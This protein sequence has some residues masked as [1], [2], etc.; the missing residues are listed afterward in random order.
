M[1]ENN[2]NN[3]DD[4]FENNSLNRE[5]E[6]L[7]EVF[8]NI[9][10][11]EQLDDEKVDESNDNLIITK[12]QRGG[13]KLCYRG[14]F[15]TIDATTTEKI[16]WKCE[17][18][19]TTKKFIKCGGRVHSN[20]RRHPVVE[21]KEHNHLPNPE[22]TECLVVIDEA[23]N[24]AELTNQK[25]RSILKSCQI[26]LS[27]EAAAQMTRFENV[28]QMILRIRSQKSDHGPNPSSADGIKISET[29]RRTYI[30]N[31]EFLWNDFEGNETTG[32]II[33]FATQRNIEILNE[34]R[35]WYADGT[36]DVAPDLFKQLFTFNVIKRGKNLPLV[37]AL[38]PDKKQATYEKMCEMIEPF[39][40][41]MPDSIMIDF[42]LAIINALRK[43][44]PDCIIIG[45]FD[46]L[47]KLI[48][49]IIFTYIL[50]LN[51]KVA[52]FI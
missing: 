2:T 50:N 7:T 26:K 11:H 4:F 52:I 43:Y 36:F 41:N 6:E 19:N 10:V 47:L 38:L 40:I 39:I 22:R 3:Q 25:P 12:T 45:L 16:V 18:C 35:E 29:L 31:E 37:Y 28:R 8:E 23:K 14:Y 17:S 15:Y 46:L 21:I 32:R 42:E 34:M 1:S 5:V 48:I 44:F 27:D 30:N 20:F 24:L 13:E 49:K 33:I 51:L 9:S